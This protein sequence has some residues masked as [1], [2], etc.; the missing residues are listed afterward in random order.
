MGFKWGGVDLLIYRK[1]DAV[2]G[3]NPAPL[4]DV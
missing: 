1:D 4:W 3:S 2:D